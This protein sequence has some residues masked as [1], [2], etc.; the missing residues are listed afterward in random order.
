MNEDKTIEQVIGNFFSPIPNTP[1]EEDRYT[2]IRNGIVTNQFARM[3]GKN[4]DKVYEDT[5][6][7]VGVFTYEDL[8]VT[9]TN[10]NDLA[11]QQTSTGMLFDAL[12]IKLTEQ[13]LTDGNIQKPLPEYMQ[14]RGIK[15]EKAAR[16]QVHKDLEILYNASIS[17]KEKSRGKI[18]KNYEDVRII[19][20]KGIKNSVINVHFTQYFL[21]ILKSYAVMPFPKTIF[22]I[23][24]NRYPNAYALWRKITELKN[25]NAGNSTADIISVKTLLSAAAL[26]S[27]EE[28]QKAH[29]SYKQK[30][31]EP[32]ERD[33]DANAD[34]YTWEYCHKKGAPL[35]QE[36]LDNF[37][38][39]VFI[40]LN[41]RIFW[42]QYPDQTKLIEDKKRKA[43]NAK[44]RLAYKKKKEDGSAAE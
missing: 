42:K 19:D 5:S 40:G 31:I 27:F 8:T 41:V 39:D 16:E 13:G 21:D 32:F 38:Y 18:A 10:V 36:E 22:Q 12:I 24:A 26:P 9:F 6:A 29:G 7:N 15:D 1:L 3:R 28:V 11:S 14:E 23:N 34:A 25:A 43:K 30:I 17:W 35:T 37:T 33:M 44:R 4:R 20:R 2:I